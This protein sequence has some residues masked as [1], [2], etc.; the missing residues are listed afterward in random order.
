MGLKSRCRK[1][2]LTLHL[3]KG[4]DREPI[5]TEVTT[6]TVDVTLKTTKMTGW[7]EGGVTTNPSLG[8][9]FNSGVRRR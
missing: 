6:L 8:G 5:R 2:G 7:W 3:L 4:P 9:I 1:E